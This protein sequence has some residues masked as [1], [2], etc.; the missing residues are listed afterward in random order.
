MNL[1]SIF[2]CF[3]RCFIIIITITISITIITK[4]TSG[5]FMI[6]FIVKINQF[7]LYVLIIQQYNANGR[8]GIK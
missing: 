4:S 7:I 3:L 5:S 1:F 8:L 2:T 6:I